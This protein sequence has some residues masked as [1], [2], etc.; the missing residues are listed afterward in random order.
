MKSALGHVEGRIALLSHPC[1]L[2]HRVF[3]DGNRIHDE[4]VKFV[5]NGLVSPEACVTRGQSLKCPVLE[6]NFNFTEYSGNIFLD[7]LSQNTEGKCP[8]RISH[9]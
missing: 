2:G 8:M 1:D 5:G 9:A 3:Q 4:D 6:L 7:F